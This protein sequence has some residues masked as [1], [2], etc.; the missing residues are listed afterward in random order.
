MSG[1]V[2]FYTAPDMDFSPATLS[3]VPVV[4]RGQA[5]AAQRDGWDVAVVCAKSAN[6]LFP[7]IKTISVDFSPAPAGGIALFFRRVERKLFQYRRI[8]HQR[9]VAESVA[10]LAAACPAGG[11]IVAPAE[12]EFGAAIASF[13][14][15]RRFL[16][17]FH[18]CNFACKPRFRRKI[19]SPNIHLFA[20]SE[21]CAQGSERYFSLPSG[22]VRVVRNAVDHK[23]FFPQPR[24]RHEQKPPLISHHGR[25]VPEKGVDILLEAAIRLA[26]SGLKF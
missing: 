23:L 9:W 3:A 2:T 22:S 26:E 15:D 16:F 10:A 11:T 17:L 12:P 5:L 24:R 20:V 8:L 4:I 19:I 1:N 18:D 25:S 7:D 6:P 14:P 13:L 21:F